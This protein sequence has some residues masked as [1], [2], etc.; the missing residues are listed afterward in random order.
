MAD[1]YISREAAIKEVCAGCG[2]EFSDEPCEPPDCE[3]MAR[4]KAIPAADVKPVVR[5]RDC[6]NWTETQKIPNC[7]S[8]YCDAL[9][10][11]GN[12]YCAAGEKREAEHD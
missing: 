5:C 6:K 8:C 1:E 11:W 9:L 7:G 2:I 4:L 3:I 12:F 10:R